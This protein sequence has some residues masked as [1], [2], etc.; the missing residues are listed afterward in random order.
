MQITTNLVSTTQHL[1]QDPKIL[2]MNKRTKDLFLKKET[3]ENE[4]ISENANLKSFSSG[5]IYYW[6]FIMRDARY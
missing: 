5:T 4:N 1:P 6:V 2:L 3:K